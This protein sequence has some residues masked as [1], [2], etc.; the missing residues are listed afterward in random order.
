VIHGTLD[1]TVHVRHG[2]ALQAACPS[3]CRHA[4][5]WVGGAT[6]DDVVEV[7][8]AAFYARLRAFMLH[9]ARR[10]GA[11]GTLQASTHSARSSDWLVGATARDDDD[12]DDAGAARAADGGAAGNADA[13]RSEWGVYAKPVDATGSAPAGREPVALPPIALQPPQ[14]TD[15]FSRGTDTLRS[16]HPDELALRPDEELRAIA[17]HLE[18]ER[19]SAAAEGADEPRAHDASAPAEIAAVAAWE[20]GAQ[21]SS[22]RSSA[23][24]PE[25][26]PRGAVP[27]V[28]GE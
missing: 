12:D 2:E 10:K 28:N 27:G 21:L 15:R 24:G 22:R 20:G 3:E 18:G 23:G 25:G 17:L 13:G 8:E 5:Y 1:E 4:P 16:V 19:S 26:L 14:P 11:D 7:D 9:C 6:H